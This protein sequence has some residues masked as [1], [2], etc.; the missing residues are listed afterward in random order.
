MPNRS[1]KRDALA[2]SAYLTGLEVEFIDGVNGSL[3]SQREYP[4]VLPQCQSCANVPLLN[5]IEL[6]DG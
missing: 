1:D 3:V 4:Q 6:E 2:L 5:G